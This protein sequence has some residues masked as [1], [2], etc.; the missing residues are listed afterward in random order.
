[1]ARKGK[2]SRIE[3]ITRDCK[4]VGTYK[5]EFAPV[6]EALVD[7]EIQRDRTRKEFEDS[8]EGSMVPFTNKNG[9]VNSAKNPRL[10][11]W[12]E[13]NLTALKYRRELGL[14]PA[15]LKKLNEQA[16]KPQKVSPLAQALKNLG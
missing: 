15:G 3:S 14:T 8:G 6:I 2:K 13:Q 16:M 4:S 1:M 12:N 9:S 5:P 11:L 10:V 7:I